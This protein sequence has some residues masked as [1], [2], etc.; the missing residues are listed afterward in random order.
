[1]EARP[2]ILRQRR[3]RA[4]QPVREHLAPAVIHG[5]TGHRHHHH[6]DQHAGDDRRPL[7][8]HHQAQQGRRQQ[9]GEHHHHAEDPAHQ[10]VDQQRRQIARTGLH[11]GAQRLAG[12]QVGVH[13]QRHVEEGVD[14]DHHGQQHHQGE[15]AQ[16]A[17][18]RQLGDQGGV[19]LPAGRGALQDALHQG[20]ALAPQHHHQQQRNHQHEHHADQQQ[21]QQAADLAGGEAGKQHRHVGRL[22]LVGVP[23]R[24]QHPAHQHHAQRAHQN[25][26]HRDAGQHPVDQPDHQQGGRMPAQ[27]GDAV[28]QPLGAAAGVD[29]VVFHDV[30]RVCPGGAPTQRTRL[31]E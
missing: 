13:H 9:A 26:D 5:A 25:T 29:L 12:G 16:Q 11:A 19:G 27:Q 28:K 7:R 23:D 31:R 4:R 2:G 21:H 10:H 1:V 6:R 3:R 17:A 24:K 8:A 20:D 14:A 22:V 30:P 15:P 18:R